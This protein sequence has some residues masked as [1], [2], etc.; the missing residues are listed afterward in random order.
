MAS[1]T[2]P[3]DTPIAK[4]ITLQAPAIYE[5]VLMIIPRRL[6]ST[7][8]TGPIYGFFLDVIESY[9]PTLLGD[10]REYCTGDDN[11]DA[12]LHGEDAVYCLRRRVAALRRL[13]SEACELVDPAYAL[14]IEAFAAA[15]SEEFHR[16]GGDGGFADDWRNWKRGA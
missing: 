16:E 12:L 13:P 5:E 6:F 3:I 9:I 10:I 7:P 2:I 15:H 4:Q 11:R 8:V 14:V 1:S